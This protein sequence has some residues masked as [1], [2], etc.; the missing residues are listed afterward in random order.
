MNCMLHYCH[1]FV[2][3]SVVGLQL[4]HESVTETETHPAR[5]GK[6]S[7]ARRRSRLQTEAGHARLGPGVIWTCRAGPGRAWPMEPPSL[8]RTAGTVTG[9]LLPS[10]RP[11]P[12]VRPSRAARRPWPRR[13]PATAA[14]PSGMPP[15]LPPARLHGGPRRRVHVCR[16]PPPRRAPDPPRA[17][18]SIARMH[19]ARGP[20]A[21]A[22]RTAITRNPARPGRAPPGRAKPGRAGPDQTGAGP[23]R[24]KTGR[25]GRAG[26]GRDGRDG[27]GRAGPCP[28]APRAARGG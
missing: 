6:A 4:G 14:P 1:G 15:P 7:T 3:A 22:R 28:C 9:G 20:V 16:R 25:T 27:P 17:C 19:G 26:P 8:S 10:W 18:D 5:L 11:G 21:A 24:A 12:G 23:G 13:A 2:R